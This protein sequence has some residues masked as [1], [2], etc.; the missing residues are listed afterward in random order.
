MEMESRVLLYNSSDTKIGE[1]SASEAREI[2]SRQRAE[3]VDN[4]HTAIRFYS[5]MEYMENIGG[6]FNGNDNY[7]KSSGLND[8]N[9]TDYNND[10]NNKDGEEGDLQIH[11][12]CFARWTDGKYY[13]AVISDLLNSH[14]KVAYL[15]GD[16]GM[17]SIEHII[18]LYEGF[19][20]LTFQ[21]NWKNWGYYD[22]VLSST[23]PLI[24]EYDD[25]EVEQ[26]NLKQ[27]RGIKR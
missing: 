17:V 11:H 20:T 23:S 4:N 6:N 25:G 27:L 13:P 15:D 5:G 16:T 12:V 3:W 9:K 24:M 2:V 1:I 10:N 7:N 18:N 22:G 19:E 8:F 14:A 26:L 21:G